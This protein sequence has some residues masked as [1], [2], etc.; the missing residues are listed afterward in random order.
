MS[1]CR[2]K[3]TEKLTKNYIK[4][5]FF[6]SILQK[7]MNLSEIRSGNFFSVRKFTIE[8]VKK[9][10]ADK[11]TSS[12]WGREKVELRWEGDRMKVR[13]KVG[14]SFVCRFRLDSKEVGERKSEEVFVP[15]QEL[16][17][18]LSE[19]F[20]GVW[21]CPGDILTA[22]DLDQNYEL[23]KAKFPNLDRYSVFSWECAYVSSP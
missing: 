9:R 10:I 7:K 1:F 15:K 14:E 3:F 19:L 23:G 20:P 16:I 17:V 5:S 8:S 4:I 22:I 12:R 11:L 18:T 13:N 6:S 21:I 2:K